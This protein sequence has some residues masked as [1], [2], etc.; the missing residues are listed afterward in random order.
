LEGLLTG[1][2]G[3]ASWFYL[4]PSLIQTASYTWNPF[5][6][7]N[8][9]FNECEEKIVVNLILRDDSN[10]GDMHNRQGLSI[11]MLRECIKTT[12]CGRYT[13]WVSPG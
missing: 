9:W 12:T 6:G 13:S 1:C 3:I 7:K 2:I 11:K 4:P 5:R 8:G 10:K